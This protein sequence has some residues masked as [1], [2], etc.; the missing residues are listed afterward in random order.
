MM[1]FFLLDG[2]I[3]GAQGF[4]G[5]VFTLLVQI[6]SF[7]G[8]FILVFGLFQGFVLE[9]WHYSEFLLGIVIMVLVGPLPGIALIA[10]QVPDF[11]N[12]V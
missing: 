4:L 3:N 7:A 1:A 6:I 9:K 10:G 8:L 12:L 5:A 11:S 2:L